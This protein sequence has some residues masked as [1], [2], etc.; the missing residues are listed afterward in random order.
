MRRLA[1]EK[2][3]DAAARAVPV[4]VGRLGDQ[5][6]LMRKRTVDAL[7]KSTVRAVFDLGGEDIWMA[8]FGLGGEDIGMVV[9][10]SGGADAARRL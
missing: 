7:G 8:A 9:L 1:L 6:G 4:L 5:D 10:G 3:K 2:S